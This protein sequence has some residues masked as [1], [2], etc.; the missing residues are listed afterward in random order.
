MD[1]KQ[2]AYDIVDLIDDKKGSDISLLD[3]Q[4]IS[5]VSDYFIIASGSSNRQVLAIAENVEDGMEKQGY[6]LRHKEGHRE[7]NWVL[8]DFGDIV[9]HVFNKEQRVFY[10]LEKLWCDAIITKF[11]VDT[12]KF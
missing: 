4:K 9:V 3:V 7:G 1:I 8:L 11:D 6:F 12:I 2:L 5:S 10:N